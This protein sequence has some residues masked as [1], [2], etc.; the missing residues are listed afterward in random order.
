LDPRIT[1]FSILFSSEE[2]IL[3]KPD[4]Q[5]TSLTPAGALLGSEGITL[6][7]AYGL[8]GSSVISTAK[9]TE[10]IIA[11]VGPSASSLIIKMS[12]DPS[13]ANRTATIFY[14]GQSAQLEMSVD[15]SASEITLDLDPTSSEASVY[16]ET[17]LLNVVDLAE[18]QIRNVGLRLESVE[19][20]SSLAKD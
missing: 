15:G 14:L 3:L 13:I 7:S 9:R 5:A 2:Y 17:S 19:L 8:S 12:L 10:L 18:D 4:N 1:G 16:I 6:S 11:Q 20:A